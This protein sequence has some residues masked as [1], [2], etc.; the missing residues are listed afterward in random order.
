MHAYYK[1]VTCPNVNNLPLKDAFEEMLLTLKIYIARDV[2][3]RFPALNC[4]NNVF[5]NA[6]A[7]WD[8]KFKSKFVFGGGPCIF[9]GH[10]IK[11]IALL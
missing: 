1:H 8:G 7:K 4:A 3:Y 11:I 2:R 5:P 9:K 6:K 10:K